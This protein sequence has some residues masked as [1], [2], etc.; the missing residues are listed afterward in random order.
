MRA[1]AH[2]PR[3]SRA[4]ASGL[5]LVTGAHGFIGRHVAR[6]LKADG[7]AVVGIGHGSWDERE[8]RAWG[9]DRWHDATIAVDVLSALGIVP[10]LVI[11]CAGTSTVTA[12]LQH[13]GREFER[14]VG[15]TE[16]VLEAMRRFWPKSLLVYPS[17][18]A[19]Y[20]EAA[21][22]PIAET[23]RVAP[24]SPYGT[25]KD[26]AEQLCRLYEHRYGVRSVLLRIFS[27]Y[28]PRLRKQLLWDAC[29]KLQ[30]GD[31]TFQGTGQEVRDWIHV[32]DLARLIAPLAAAPRPEDSVPV[33]NVGTGAGTTVFDVVHLIADAFGL[34]GEPNFTGERRSGDP[35]AFVADISRA[36]AL[37]WTPVVP[38][39]QGVVD[40]VRWFRTSQVDLHTHP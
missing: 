20:G 9:I 24:I 34:A 18:G 4:D 10:D 40:Y 26:Q 39:A 23:E 28:G 15:S 31:A 27:V 16:A 5:A 37:G 19:V 3:A 25:F 11:H 12:A 30:V 29:R 32:D 1:A 7:W 17:S 38:V 33:I 6:Q 36:R 14:T 2:S 35:A 13:P 8:W 21:A 22:L